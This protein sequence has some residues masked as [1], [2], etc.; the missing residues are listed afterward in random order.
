MLIQKH[1]V[2]IFLALT[3]FG[4]ARIVST[5]NVFSHTQD[6]PAHIACGMEYLSKGV[7]RYEA[8][9]PPLARVAAACVRTMSRKC[10][11]RGRRCYT[12]AATMT[13]IFF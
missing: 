10:R 9:H 7:Y 4:S 3:A 11:M 13:A 12:K 2:W 1:S 8:Q 6:E 5:Y